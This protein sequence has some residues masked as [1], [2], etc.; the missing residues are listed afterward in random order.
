MRYSDLDLVVKNE[1]AA[2][3]YPWTKR[4]FIDCLRSGYQSWVLANKQ[5]IAA[6]GVMSV[7][8]GECH[9]LTLC[10][11]PEFQR[12]GYGRRLFTLLLDRAANL[13]AKE[14][15]LEVRVSNHKAIS[16]YR[17]I[18]FAQIGER[19]N[20]YPGDTG[21]EDALILARSLPLP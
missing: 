20:Y 11:H 3:D 1:T 5:E 17:S 2:Y 15:F 18:G 14:C 4:I 10:V 7:A 12:M 21:R 13:D 6:H 19:S 8:I 16:L 9:L